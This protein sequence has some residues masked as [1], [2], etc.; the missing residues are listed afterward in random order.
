MIHLNKNNKLLSIVLAVAIFINCVISILLVKKLYWKAPPAAKNIKRN[1]ILYFLN[2][3]Q[4]F[5]VFPKDSNSIIFLGNSLTQN[6]EV[7]ELLKNLKIKNRGI[8]GDFTGGVLNRINSII[9]AHPQKVFI[10]IGLNDLLHNIPLDT[11]IRN[12]QTLIDTLHTGTS[13]TQVYVQSLLPIGNNSETANLPHIND[14]I[15]FINEQLKQY[16]QKHHATYVDL[17]TSFSL[18]GKINPKF[19]IS[20]GE[21]VTGEGYMLWAELVKPYVNE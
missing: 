21:H 20:D 19:F 17:Y 18:E 16:A 8:Y 13:A 3:Q 2:R 11:I 14:D 9:Q 15:R 5:E 10:E 6:F 12:Y 1:A 4:Y 7:T